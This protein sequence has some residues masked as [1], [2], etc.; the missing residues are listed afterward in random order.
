MILYRRFWY[1]N[2]WNSKETVLKSVLTRPFRRKTFLK[3]TLRRLHNKTSSLSHHITTQQKEEEYYANILCKHWVVSF[4][5]FL[6]SKEEALLLVWSWKNTMTY[7]LTATHHMYTYIGVLVYRELW[8]DR[9][10][11][12]IYISSHFWPSKHVYPIIIQCE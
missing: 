4:T 3:G 8:D 2:I 1:L 9:K 6:F 5:F 12:L 10:W 11:W 7:L